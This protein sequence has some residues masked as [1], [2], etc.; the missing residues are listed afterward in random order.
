[1]SS[2]VFLRKGNARENDGTTIDPATSRYLIRRLNN[3]LND[4]INNLIRIKKLNK[5]QINKTIN[6][7]FNKN[8]RSWIIQNKIFFSE[9]L[10]NNKLRNKLISN[11]SLINKTQFFIYQRINSNFLRI[12]INIKNRLK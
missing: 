3:D 12:L 6:L 9:I 11:L 4:Y 1:M 7:I 10:I 2:I 5:E 8:F